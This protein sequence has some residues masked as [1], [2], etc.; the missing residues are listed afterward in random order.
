[1]T[2]SGRWCGWSGQVGRRV[3]VCVCM[4]VCAVLPGLVW[5]GLVCVPVCLS[6]R[7]RACVC[8]CACVG[9]AGCV[10]VRTFG[11]VWVRCSR[12]PA[13]WVCSL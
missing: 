1:M 10:A 8:V 2:A 12:Y 5:I 9:M 4:Y 13:N 11:C 3:G 6:V 7:V